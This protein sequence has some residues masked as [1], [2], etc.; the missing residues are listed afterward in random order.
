MDLYCII[1][2]AVIYTYVL[3]LIIQDCTAAVWDVKSPTAI[4]LRTVLHHADYVTVCEVDSSENIIIT[5]SAEGI[6][7]VQS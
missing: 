6:I 4:T 1:V 2:T 5:G 7:T 3:A